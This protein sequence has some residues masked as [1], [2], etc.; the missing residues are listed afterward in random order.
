MQKIYPPIVIADYSGR[1][2]GPIEFKAAHPQDK[3]EKGVPHLVVNSFIFQ[4]DSYKNLLVQKRGKVTGAGKWD[5]SVGGHI[6]WIIKEKRGQ[7]PEE[8]IKR[9]LME[10]LFYNEQIP[11]ELKLE[12]VWQGWKEIFPHNKEY[13]ALF[14]GVYAGPFHLN[15]EEVQAVQFLDLEFIL[16]DASS[17]PDYY[18]KDLIYLI[19]KYQ[20]TL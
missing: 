4:D 20:A 2:V 1:P 18:T 15:S 3:S 11:E 8:A 19:K 7:T 14:R 16:D 6:D 13:I 5:S 17:N 12:K 10:E 9:E